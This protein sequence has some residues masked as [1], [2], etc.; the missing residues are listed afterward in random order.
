M[1]D[2]SLLLLGLSGPELTPDEAALFRNLQPAGYVISA[3]NIVTPQQTRKLTDDLRDLS[4]DLPVIAIDQEGGRSHPPGK[5][6]PP[7]PPQPC[8]QRGKTSGRSP[9]PEPSPAIFCGC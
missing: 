5:S 2:G 8:L 1:M 9:R 3:R 4:Y 6:L 7:P